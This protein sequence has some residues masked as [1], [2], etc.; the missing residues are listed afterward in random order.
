VDAEIVDQP[1]PT[2]HLQDTTD[3]D[4]ALI[5]DIRLYI[6]RVGQSK[7]VAR[8]TPTGKQHIITALQNAI[9]NIE[10]TLP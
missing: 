7:E 8:L 10:R 4:L 9:T 6:N 2:H 1:T 5:N 3:R